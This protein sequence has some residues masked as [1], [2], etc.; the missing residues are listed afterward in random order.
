MKTIL[1]T[2]AT[3]GIGLATS[4]ALSGQGHHLLL[5]GRSQQKLTELADELTDSNS[6]ITTLNADLSDF[7]QVNA[8]IASIVSQHKHIDV[9]LNNA[10]VFKTQYPHKRNELDVR[11]K[12]NLVAPYLIIKGLQPRLSQHSRIIN[13]SSAAQAECQ[14]DIFKKPTEISDAMQAY[15]QS[16]MAIT[17][18][19]FACANSVDFIGNYIALNPGSLLATKMVKEGFGVSGNSI[20]M[21]V[22]V[23]EAAIHESRFLSP[24]GCYFDNDK[25]QFSEPLRSATHPDYQQALLTHLTH[26]L[27]QNP[28]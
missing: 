14:L 11:L 4:K 2:G 26:Y 17:A 21:G 16:K 13:V 1:I 9:I 28:I 23:F 15:A 24:A 12:V 10:G 7:S 20:E 22:K 6:Q 25:G 19:T 27:S 18:M 5:H 3:D 8:M